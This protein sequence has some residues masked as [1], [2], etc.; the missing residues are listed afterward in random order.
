MA[1]YYGHYKAVKLLLDKGAVV[2]TK[3][4]KYAME[5]NFRSDN[6]VFLLYQNLYNHA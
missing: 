3:C 1:C 6:V 5:K 4:L 2:D